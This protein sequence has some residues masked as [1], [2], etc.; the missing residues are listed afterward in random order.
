MVVFFSYS[1][2]TP[3]FTTVP[4]GENQKSIVTQYIGLVE[5]TITYNSPNVTDPRG[6]DRTGH[7]WGEL[8]PYGMSPNTF[9]RWTNGGASA[10]IPWRAGSNENTT[11]SFSHDVVIEG[12]PLKAGKYSL[13]ILTEKEEPWTIIFNKDANRWGSFFYRDS[14]DALRVKVPARENPFNEWLTYG[15]SNRFLK[16]ATAFMEW[17]KKRIEFKIEVPNIT[18][19]YL[20]N[21]RTEMHGQKGLYWENWVAAANFCLQNNTGNWEEALQ[22]TVNATYWARNYQ[23]L[24]AKAK[25]LEKLNRQKEADSAWAQALNNANSTL[26]DLLNYANLQLG[27]NQ[28]EKVFEVYATAEK[29]YPD[30]KHQVYMSMARAYWRLAD[31]TNAIAHFDKAISNWPAAEKDGLESAKREVEFYKKQQ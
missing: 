2:T 24:S 4:I 1:Q 28:K 21:W 8:V 6:K 22:W 15:F 27:K 5:V 12:Q 3:T 16:S 13:F 25:V 11:I 30:F 31:K 14:E 20:A 17:E 26:T 9:P 18:D 19:Y 23:T 29:K 7:I 10:T